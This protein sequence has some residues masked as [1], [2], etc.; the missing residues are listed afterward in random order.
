[1]KGA[2]AASTRRAPI[3]VEE[4]GR[5]DVLL[6]TAVPRRRLFRQADRSEGDVHEVKLFGQRLNDAAISIEAVAEQR[7]AEVAAK[8][9]GTTFAEV[10]DGRA[11]VQDEG[12]QLVAL[13]A[14]EAVL[15]SR[16]GA[17]RPGGRSGPR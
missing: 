4:P 16:P 10:R 8:D 15:T 12:S 5:C 1:M 2:S 11:A 14:L 6:R 17:P 9:L 13:A 7:L 3:V